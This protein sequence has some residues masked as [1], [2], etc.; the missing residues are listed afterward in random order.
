MHRRVRPRHHK[1]AYQVF[2]F[3]IDLDELPRLD[4]EIAGFGH[5]RFSAFAFHDRDHGPGVAQP[6]RP[7]IERHLADAGVALDGGRIMVM[8]YPRTLGYV[9]NP[10]TVYFCYRRATDGNETLAAVCYE[11]TNTFKQRHTYVIPVTGTDADG[12]VRQTCGKAL[13]VSP[14]VEMDMTYHFRVLPPDEELSVTIRETDADGPLLFASFTGRRQPL[15]SA[16][17]IR[18]FC[19]FP[20]LTLKVIGG[21]HWEALKL[22]LKGV[23]V[24]HR[25]GPPSHP[26]SIITGASESAPPAAV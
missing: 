10:L 16:T 17:V 4:R 6:L 3:L 23:P 19:A 15:S 1:L 8:C 2:S 14:F 13:Y 12:I 5:N 21:I 18:A 25:P 20:L 9:F 26:V 7:W 24:V 11:V 22:W